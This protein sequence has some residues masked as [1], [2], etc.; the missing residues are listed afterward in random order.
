MKNIQSFK[1]T[2]IQVLIL[3]VMTGAA[4]NAMATG[5]ITL[6]SWGVAGVAPELG[7]GETI[8][9]TKSISKSNWSG[10]PTLNYSAWAH[11]G[12]TPW[13]SFHLTEAA[14]LKIT[15]TAANPSAAAAANFNPAL[16]LWTSGA[17]EFDTGTSNF[18]EIA[19]NGWNAP[20]SFNAVGQ[21]GDN[22][23]YWMSYDPNTDTVMGNQLETLAYANTG[24]SYTSG[25]GWDEQI[26]SGVHDVSVTN[27]Y[28]SGIYGTAVLGSNSLELNV[29]S[30]Q[31]G[32]FTLFIGGNNNASS[33]Q[34]YVLAVNAAPAVPVPAAAWLMGSGL[35]GLAGIARRRNNAN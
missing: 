26:L 16:S 10:N 27:T 11:A 4:S 12:G 5:A 15:L 7:L 20:H 8:S 22:G 33:T 14:N 6:Q 29:I 23:T 19:S 9:V 17:N 24:A 21:I 3:G 32:W 30:A 13:Y 28:E 18:D 35:I 31:A 25:T 2:A 1:R 34:G